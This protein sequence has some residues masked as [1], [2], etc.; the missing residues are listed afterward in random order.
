MYRKPNFVY[1]DLGNVI[2][3]FSHARM[4]QQIAVLLRAEPEETRKFLFS[5]E[6]SLPY[7]RG[8]LTT[9]E[10]IAKLNERFQAQL[11]VPQ[12][13]QALGDIFW[14]NTSI[15]P[16]I[17]GLKS[18]GYGIGILSNTCDAHWEV[19]RER[20]SILDSMFDVQVLSFRVDATKPDQEIYDKAA[21][22]AGCSTRELFFVDDLLENVEGAR[23]A[24]VD[25]VLFTNTQSLADDLRRRHL[26]FRY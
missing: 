24:G 26:L 14:L 22:I 16:L 11:S 25:A 15:I 10:L 1:F 9:D 21:E 4:C 20:F 2:L 23:Q 8:R 3:H 17:A 6:I 18:A 13:R 12:A 7:E 5:P 19:A